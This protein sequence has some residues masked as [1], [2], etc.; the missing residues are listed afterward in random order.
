MASKEYGAKVAATTVKK[1]TSG[2]GK[3]KPVSNM[4]ITNPEK[5]SQGPTSG[6]TGD[7]VHKTPSGSNKIDTVE[8]KVTESSGID[9]REAASELSPSN[10]ATR[11][12]ETP[13]LANNKDTVGRKSPSKASSPSVPYPAYSTF[14]P[15]R[16][17]QMELKIDNLTKL[18]QSQHE[19]LQQQLLQQ[20]ESLQE[21][22]QRKP[23][24][25][26]QLQ[27][28]EQTHKE[29]LEQQEQTHK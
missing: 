22:L 29:Q 26:Q 7:S 2:A 20:E 12:N 8:R 25:Q 18:E 5:G 15:D 1:S 10:D 16:L 4:P 23:R 21:L 6:A 3:N 27:Q 14:I 17:K 24:L 13:S 19:Q 28:Q 9:T 11:H